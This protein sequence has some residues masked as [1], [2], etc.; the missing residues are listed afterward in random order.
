MEK[1]KFYIT[2]AIDYT[3]GKPHMGHVFE[4]I[5]TDIIARY[6]RQKGD[7][8]YFLTG[9]DENGLKNQ[10]TAEENGV[11]PKEWVDKTVKD[12]TSM[13]EDFNLSYDSFIRTSDERHHKLVKEIWERCK[14]KGDIYKKNYKGL[15]CVGCEGFVKESDLVDGKCPNHNKAPE[16][17]EEENWFF[18]LSNYKE[19]L[20]GIIEKQELSIYPKHR[21]K[22]ILNI[23]NDLEDFSVS[24]PKE[25][26]YWGVEVPDDPTQVM[27]VWFDALSN[28]VT[29]IDFSLDSEKFKKYWP[30]DLHVIGK[31]I[32]RFHIIYWPAM[33][34]SA[35]IELPKAILAHGFVNSGGKKMSKSLGNSIDPQEVLSRHGC[36][37]LRFF[38][39]REIPTTEDGDFTFER[40]DERYNTDLA[41]S[42][43]NLVS[44]VTNIAD[45]N[46]IKFVDLNLEKINIDEFFHEYRLDRALEKIWEKI[47]E[48]NKYVDDEKPWSI[49]DDPEKLNNVINNL[50]N[51]IKSIGEALAPFMPETSEKILNIFD[52][53]KI[54]K[55]DPLFPRKE[56]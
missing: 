7:D 16:V 35:G 38:I 22:E 29:G 31:D 54:L 56:K 14:E 41:N 51:Q 53:E 12:F 26:L 17:I 8:V 36:D 30:A 9:S 6:H 19:Q 21:A 13:K 11:T 10:I 1:E 42:L 15:Y 46:E 37:P 39:T 25:K 20:K 27:Y 2:T 34:L 24:R 40:F 5:L 32:T 52:G 28:Y 47:Y 33:L 4:K 55:A 44:R 50:L 45:K 18:K 48:A 49:K 23:L 3:N 43:G